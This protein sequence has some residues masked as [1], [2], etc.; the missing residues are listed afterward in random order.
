MHRIPD[1]S[2]TLQS[3]AR[4]NFRSA[5]Y[6]SHPVSEPSGRFHFV[7]PPTNPF[8]ATD[9][10]QTAL[11]RRMQADKRHE[12]KRPSLLKTCLDAILRR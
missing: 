4:E 1:M 8:P 3:I 7:Q 11:Q 9:T 5:G 6:I 2:P 12:P 10:L